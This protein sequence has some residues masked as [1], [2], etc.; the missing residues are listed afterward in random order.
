MSFAEL[1]DICGICA[2]LVRIRMSDW[3]IAFCWPVQGPKRRGLDELVWRQ[4]RQQARSATLVCRIIIVDR[5][6]QFL[7]QI[8]RSSCW[9]ELG[10]PLRLHCVFPP[11][12]T[13]SARENSSDPFL[14]P[15]GQPGP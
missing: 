1:R 4:T 2:C 13:R 5:L 10:Q 9:N 7:P 15:S 3:L 6:A 8:F 12:S 11:S 14:M